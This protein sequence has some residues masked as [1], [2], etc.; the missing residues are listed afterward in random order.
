MVVLEGGLVLVGS[1]EDDLELLALGI[2][3]IVELGQDRSEASAR[4]TPVSTEVDPNGADA[5]EDLS[6][7]TAL[8]G[9]EIAS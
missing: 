9:H 4:R 5:L 1:H 2:D 3:L 8:L 6:T 7:G